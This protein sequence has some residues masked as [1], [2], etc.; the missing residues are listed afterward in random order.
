MLYFI[1]EVR[2]IRL[3]TVKEKCEVFIKNLIK[4]FF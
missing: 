4:P 1:L 2:R 3:F